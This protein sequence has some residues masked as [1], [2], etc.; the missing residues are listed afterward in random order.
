MQL[1]FVCLCVHIFLACYVSPPKPLKG[2]HLFTL[3]F[4]LSS[5]CWFWL[6]EN[7]KSHIWCHRMDMNFFLFP[8]LIFCNLIIINSHRTDNTLKQKERIGVFNHLW[9]CFVKVVLHRIICC[10]LYFPSWWRIIIE[11]LFFSFFLFFLNM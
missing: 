10:R 3:H 2:T 6:S 9:E 7:V 5:H 11:C 4:K 1:Y 8:R